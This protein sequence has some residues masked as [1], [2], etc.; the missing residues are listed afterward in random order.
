MKVCRY[1]RAAPAPG[2]ESGRATVLRSTRDHGTLAH[3][4]S[5]RSI[6]VAESENQAV[7]KLLEVVGAVFE[8]HA[9]WPTRHYVGAVLDQD[10]DLDLGEALAAAP[11]SLLLPTGPQEDSKVVLTVAGLAAARDDGDVGRFIEALRWA[12][13]EALG[14]RPSDPREV[15]EVT[16]EAGQFRAEWESRGTRTDDSDLA[17]LHEMFLTEGIYS[18]MGGEG[19]DWTIKLDR[20]RAVPYREIDT[21]A[22]YLKM[23]QRPAMVIT[24]PG[25]RVV[26]L[27]AT[28]AEAEEPRRK[29]SEEPVPGS[30]S[31]RVEAACAG[32]FADGH[33][34]L[35][36]LEA[37]KVMRD[38][39]REASGLRL[40]GDQ[41][42]GKALNPERPLIV[43]GDLATETGGS[44]QRGV[45]LIA[46]GIFAAVRNPLEHERVE[47]GVRE[48]GRMISMVGFVV[49]AIESGSGAPDDEDPDI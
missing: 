1:A 38:V 27:D 19:H 41:L 10:H 31:P 13:A 20:Q 9:S 21:L 37:V 39:L 7:V 36:V 46:Q 48:A 44:R 40:D 49:E 35:G 45:M 16:L 6:V 8:E 28:L 43:L 33:L 29:G 25:A 14:T 26:D 30:V 5:Y 15:V 24:L 47:V 22:D 3:Q 34:R 2:E 18:W 32:L 23:K 42:A 4:L 11:R 17:K 12:V